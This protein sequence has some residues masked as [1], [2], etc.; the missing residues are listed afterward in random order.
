M[1]VVTRFAEGFMN[2][3]QSGAET[4][5]SW[6]TGIVPVVL[7]LM[8]LMNALIAI[9]GEERM[10]KLGELSARN[11]LTRYMILPFL[12]AFMLGNPMA[13]SMGRFLPEFY[14]PSFIASQMQF[15][16]TSNGIFPHINPGE[17]FVWLGIASGIQQ[18]GLNEMDLA[19]RYLLVGLIMNAVGGWVTDFTTAWVSKQQG[20]TLS[21]EVKVV[22]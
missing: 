20:V 16:H 12:S 5:I 14:K 10:N 6:M 9:I 21:K 11:P 18:L 15:C 8:V 17:L 7:M 13:M 22:N 4:F 2:L 19:I 3:F 1:N